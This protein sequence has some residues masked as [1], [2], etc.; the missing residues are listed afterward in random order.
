MK[1]VP[2]LAML[3]TMAVVLIADGVPTAVTYN[4]VNIEQ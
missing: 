4:A 3:L 2:A 1:V